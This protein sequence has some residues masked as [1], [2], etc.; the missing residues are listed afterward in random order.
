MLLFCLSKPHAVPFNICCDDPLVSLRPSSFLAKAQ[1]AAFY[2]PLLFVVNAMY[3]ALRFWG[4][5][6]QQQQ[7]RP[8]LSLTL[9]W[10]EGVPLLAVAF[11]QWYAYTGILA[12]ASSRKAGDN[13]TS[14]VGGSNLDLL[15]M[16]ILVQYGSLFW[17]RKLYYLLLAAPI[18]WMYSLYATFFG[19]GGS[20]N[21]KHSAAESSDP[22]PSSSSVSDKQQKRADKRRQKWS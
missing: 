2:R 13:T 15:A 7:Q 21:N 19:G 1:V 5:W 14:L 10:S 4:W 17:T 9:L 16:T 3:V 12:S 11:L 8:L 6:R 18:F 22:E 20:S